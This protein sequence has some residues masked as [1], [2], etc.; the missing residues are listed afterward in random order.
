MGGRGGRGGGGGEANQK[1]AV[2]PYAGP[3]IRDFKDLWTV[4]IFNQ[5]PGYLLK[6]M[7][8]FVNISWNGEGVS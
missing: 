2:I 6:L 1:E 7:F 8:T 4:L 5:I 3:D